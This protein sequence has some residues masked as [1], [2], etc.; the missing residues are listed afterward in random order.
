MVA[1]PHKSPFEIPQRH[2]TVRLALASLFGTVEAPEVVASYQYASSVITDIDEF[3]EA[4]GSTSQR[5]DADTY[6][7]I[8]T[9]L[10]PLWTLE[11]PA[12]RGSM[13]P[14]PASP[15]AGV[16]PLV[17]SR[18]HPSQTR[19]LPWTLSSQQGT[20]TIVAS[21]P[22]RPRSDAT[23]DIPEFIDR[24][25]A[26]ARSTSATSLRALRR[27]VPPPTPLLPIDKPEPE[28]LHLHS[29]TQGAGTYV[30][31]RNIA[32]PAQR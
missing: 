17:A 5:S 9:S 31:V 22:M 1:G 28:T 14:A 2:S 25:G 20:P 6:F 29:C 19:S 15:W 10:G 27:N 11:F 3:L 12:L 18:W 24:P 26:L 7:S 16:A 32:L 4:Q 21:P 30:F 23:M 13:T 8:A